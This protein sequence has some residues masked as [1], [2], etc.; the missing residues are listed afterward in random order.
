MTRVLSLLLAGLL[1]PSLAAAANLDDA[2]LDEARIEA[3]LVHEKSAVQRAEEEAQRR[4]V[5]RASMPAIEAKLL[6][7]DKPKGPVR[8]KVDVDQ[9][10][11]LV[12]ERLKLTT[13]TGRH[14]R[15]V[16]FGVE[17]KLLRFMVRERR[18]TAEL[19][20]VRESVVAV[21]VL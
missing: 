12:G 15:G 8:G 20:L 6:G 2:A 11:K 4:E 16:L 18:G 5:E 3:I 14:L 10:P 17:G 19:E 9:L 1:L 7:L 13:N 21:E